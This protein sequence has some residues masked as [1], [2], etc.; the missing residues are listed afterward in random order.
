MIFDNSK[1][2]GFKYQGMTLVVPKTIDSFG[3]LA[4]AAAV[5]W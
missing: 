4:P 2:A 1:Y 3:L 5:L